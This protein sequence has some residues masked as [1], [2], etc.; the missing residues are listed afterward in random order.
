MCSYN[1]V[2]CDLCGTNIMMNSTTN[3][4]ADYFLW[5]ISSTNSNRIFMSSES[6]LS[7]HTTYTESKCLPFGDYGLVV[8]YLENKTVFENVSYS[9]EVAEELIYGRSNNEYFESEELFTVCAS[10][11]DC[12][13]FNGCT[14]DVCDPETRL[15]ENQVMNDTDCS[16]CTWVTVELT[17]D[18]YPDETSWDL[19]SS[20]NKTQ[21]SVLSGK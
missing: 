14:T 2:S 18:N 7:P 5:D 19:A 1:Q 11:I 4:F 13:D 3:E 20:V 10:D 21:F 6:S 8:K 17:L 12:L 15:C 16:N 9:L